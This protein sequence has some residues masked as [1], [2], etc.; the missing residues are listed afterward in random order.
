MDIITSHNVLP[1]I[2]LEIDMSTNHLAKPLACFKC[3]WVCN[4]IIVCINMQLVLVWLILI[5][6]SLTLIMRSSIFECYTCRN[7]FWMLAFPCDI[8]IV[9][10]PQ[11]VESCTKGMMHNCNNSYP[12]SSTCNLVV[13]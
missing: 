11:N 9:L 5:S 8:Y 12:I 7:I 3:M 1:H 10:G 2:Q 13:D 6:L 4:S